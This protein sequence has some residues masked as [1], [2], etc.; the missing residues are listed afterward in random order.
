MNN[1]PVELLDAILEYIYYEKGLPD[2]HTLRACALISRAWAEPAQRLLFRRVVLQKSEDRRKHLSF[3]EATDPNTDRGRMLGQHVRVLQIFVGQK[4]IDEFDSED[5]PGLLTHTPRL[6]ELGL[7][8]GRLHQFSPGTLEKLVRLASDV[9]SY[10]DSASGSFVS[11]N[12]CPSGPLRIR[13][14]TIIAC[15][16]QSPI[17]YQLLQ[18]W[19]TIEFLHIGV[20]IA[21][22]P[23]KWTPQ[24]QLYQ[25]SLTRTPPLSVLSW[26]LSTS[27]E[28][29]RVVSFR[30]A[31]GRALYPLLQT[32]GPR[33]RSLGLM[34]YNLGAAAVLKH[35]PNLE[36]LTVV[37][38]SALIPL[39][40]L[41]STLEHLSYRN[42]QSVDVVINTIGSLPR[43]RVVTCDSRVTELKTCAELESLCASKGIEL[44]LDEVPFWV[45]EDPIHVRR[46]PRRRVASN[47]ALMN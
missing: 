38:L 13:A 47:F 7:H 43:L 33:L 39:R 10:A 3:C 26:L 46:F 34:N 1:L 19:P 44:F 36:E 4:S 21:A 18:A 8:I 23:P 27:T 29:L 25:L 15:G 20:E 31:P 42:L 17:L 45:R 28:S 16:V 35:C 9:T 24:F 22:P 5:V 30:D 12:P 41:P 37:Q 2:R 14:L 6:Y 32:I 40:G 11:S